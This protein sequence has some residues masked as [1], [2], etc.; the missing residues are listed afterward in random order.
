MLVLCGELGSLGNALLEFAALVD[1]EYCS[2]H[3]VTPLREACNR[4]NCLVQKLIAD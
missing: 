3:L 1:L 2:L 4:V